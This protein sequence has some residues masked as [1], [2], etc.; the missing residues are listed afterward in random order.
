M[1]SAESNRLRLHVD[2]TDAAV[3]MASAI[4]KLNTIHPPGANPI[5]WIKIATKLVN[6]ELARLKR[7]S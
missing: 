7:D 5:D 4:H 6:A 2:L 3:D 1:E